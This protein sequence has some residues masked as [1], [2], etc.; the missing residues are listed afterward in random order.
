MARVI[1]SH[2]GIQALNAVDKSM[3]H[4]KIQRSVNGRRRSQFVFGLDLIQK[5]IG[6]HRFVATPNEFQDALAERGQSA[7]LFQANLLRHRSRSSHTSPMIM[8]ILPGV[9]NVLFQNH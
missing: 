2:V 4:E 5:V 6:A 8:L 3:L 1:T 9:K 7:S